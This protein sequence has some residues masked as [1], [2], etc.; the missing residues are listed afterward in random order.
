LRALC[1]FILTAYL[2]PSLPPS[3]PPSLCR[4]RQESPLPL[5]NPHRRHPPG[6]TRARDT[7]FFEGER[8]DA[9][10]FESHGFASGRRRRRREGEREGGGGGGRI[11]VVVDDDDEC[12][13][14][15]RREGGREGEREG[16]TLGG[17]LS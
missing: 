16:A 6:A 9:D 15:R 8:D 12:G 2:I 17:I 11:V 14:V 10:S 7:H 3:L 1:T 5:P 4:Y 13:E